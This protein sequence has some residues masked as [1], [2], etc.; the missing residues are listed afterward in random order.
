MSNYFAF[1]VFLAPPLA[2]AASFVD[3]VPDAESSAAALPGLGAFGFD[4]LAC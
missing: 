3:G 1:G 4:V 2:G